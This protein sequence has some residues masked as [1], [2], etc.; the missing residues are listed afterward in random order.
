MKPAY[1]VIS[2]TLSMI[3]GAMSGAAPNA[4]RIGIL[5]YS[6]ATASGGSTIGDTL[7]RLTQAEIVHSTQMEGRV[8]PL[9]ADLN[10]DQ[11]Y[12]KRVVELGKASN[13]DLIVLGT[14]LDAHSEESSQSST[15]HSFFGQS[16]TANLHSIRATVTIQED[17]YD[18][19]SGK[20]LDSFRVTQTQTDRELS[21]AAE[22][23]LGSTDLFSSSFQ[24]SP[25]GK[26]MQ[27]TI[28]DLVK[29]LDA[30]K[31]KATVRPGGPSL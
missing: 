19:A 31:G 15:P 20:K 12:G 25:L 2:A 23:S 7:S 1:F 30:D 18:V 27:K 9:P 11:L 10:P 17:V 16:I 4:V 6:D 5:P 13:V 21:G 22:T 24:N 29:R 3:C 8:V 28:A 14:L 26:A